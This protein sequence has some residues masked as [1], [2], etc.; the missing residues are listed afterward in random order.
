MP[1]LSPLSISALGFMPRP[2]AEAEIRARVQT[3]YLGRQTVLSRVLGFNK[4]FLST[5]DLGFS[6]HVMLDGFW[7]IWLTLFFARS[8]KAGMVALDIGANF[9]YYSVLLGA[10]VG[11]TVA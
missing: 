8:V 4:M 9:G 5:T 1:V 10:A 11:P 2:E 3:V 6:L 7:E